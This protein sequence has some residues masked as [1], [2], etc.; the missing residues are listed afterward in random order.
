MFNRTEEEERRLTL[1]HT[2]P[3]SDFIA[4]IPGKDEVYPAG[5]SDD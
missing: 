1:T 5:L 3:P 2:G 4:R